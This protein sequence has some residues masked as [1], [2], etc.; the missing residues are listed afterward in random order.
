MSKIKL[1]CARD[2]LRGCIYMH[3]SSYWSISMYRSVVNMVCIKPYWAISSISTHDTWRRAD[4]P[5]KSVSHRTGTYLPYQAVCYG[6][7]NFV[8][9]RLVLVERHQRQRKV[10]YLTM[11]STLGVWSEMIS[12][13]ILVIKQFR[14]TRK[15]LCSVLR[16]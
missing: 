14:L 11:W 3:G 10:H 4:V 12:P 6:K 9:M 7:V 2:W 13:C 16:L 15:A 5:P 1:C 8:Y